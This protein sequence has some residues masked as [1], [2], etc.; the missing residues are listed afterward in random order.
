ML[1]AQGPVSFSGGLHSN[2]SCTTCLISAPPVLIS[3]PPVSC[4]HHSSSFLHHLSSFLH[5]LSSFLHHLSH[6]CTTCPISAPPVLILAHLNLIVCRLL[7][8]RGPQ[9]HRSLFVCNCVHASMYMQLATTPLI[10][11]IFCV[12]SLASV[13]IQV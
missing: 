5:H 10:K 9:P 7:R 8:R 13:G 4:L 2:N 6:F 11:R 12:T 3:A 1:L